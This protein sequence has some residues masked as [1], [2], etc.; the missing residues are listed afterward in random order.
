MAGSQ[1]VQPW[2]GG[3]CWSN[4]HPCNF[5]KN[6]FP[7]IK[8]DMSMT[9]WISNYVKFVSWNY[10]VY[11]LRGGSVNMTISDMSQNSG[12][13][14]YLN[15][16]MQSQFGLPKDICEP[17]VKTASFYLS[18]FLPKSSKL[19]ISKQIFVFS[20]RNRLKSRKK[21]NFRY[22]KGPYHREC[23][24]FGIKLNMK[25]FQTIF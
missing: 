21:V 16:L 20:R 10:L 2:R 22:R 15:L 8:I 25:L 4:S 14:N 19:G 24:I 3:G 7:C 6:Q 11:P 5:A 18:P 1:R 17:M 12:Q 9:P 13:K 23:M